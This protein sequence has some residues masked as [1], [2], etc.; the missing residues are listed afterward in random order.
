MSIGVR[1]VGPA[2]LVPVATIPHG[3][4]TFL[5]T[6][7]EGSTRL[8]ERYPEPMR[9]AL[10]VH[11]RILRTTIETHGGYV[12]S[13]AGDAFSAAYWTP[14]DAIETAVEAQRRLVEVPW[15]EPVILRVRMGIHTGTADERDGDY[16]G[17]ALNLA[18]RLMS[19]GHGGQIL[20]SLAT[21]ELVR[22]RS[23]EEL[24]FLGLGE[25]IFTGLGRAEK[26]FQ[27]SGPGLERDFP[28]LRTLRP[29][30]GNLARPLTSF[31]G[32]AAE[33]ERLVAELPQRRLITLTGPGGV[34]KTRLA[35]ESAWLVSGAYPD[36]T[37]LVE[38][39]RADRADAVAA[40][41]AEALG[42]TRQSGL[43]LMDSIA[44]TLSNR[45]ILVVI[46]NAEHV[47]DAT[48][49]LLRRIVR[50]CD[51][52]TVLVTSREPLTIDGERVWVV[53]PLDPVLE[54]VELFQDRVGA[55]D[56]ADAGDNRAI[57]EAL[58]RKLDGIPLAIE[59]AAARARS[60]TPADLLARL[61]DRFRLLR[62]VGRD[63]VERHQTMQAAVDWSYQLLRL[64]EQQ[65]F[66]RLAGFPESFDLA[67]A[68]QVCLDGRLDEFDIDDLLGSL[69][70]K[71]MVVAEAGAGGIRYRLLETLRQYG[72]D[73]LEDHGQMAAVQDRHI[74][75]YRVVASKARAD[76]EGTANAAGH[77]R[78][79]S[80]WDN[81]RA[82]LG[83]AIARQDAA[84]ATAIVEA[85]FWYAY[86][87]LN[88][89]H[90]D[91]AD[92]VLALPGAGI[93]VHGVA[94]MW[95]LIRGETS[96]G[97]HHGQL[98]LEKAPFPGHPGT[99][100]CWMAVANSHWYL[101]DQAEAGLAIEK[102]RLVAEAGDDAWIIGMASANAANLLVGFDNAAA[103]ASAERARRVRGPA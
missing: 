8:W 97:L 71:S 98:G 100:L 44:D 84:A 49:E 67:A 76:Y 41:V 99:A 22:D 56:A 53:P 72:R 33:L 1:P 80:E 91:W 93:S 63:R 10:A 45:R 35:L 68:E 58:C 24:G 77:A 60:M 92:H 36:G 34:G 70:D 89:E 28:P 3:T 74:A 26:V 65:V 66:D 90:G 85:S 6:D 87:G 103:A 75:H 48:A 5:F 7:V 32:R 69:V 86:W 50:G 18:A 61:G 16:F 79:E 81:L 55:V 37:W 95:A 43:S 13:T 96:D 64:E 15:P 59:L 39:A 46:D 52:L 82:A 88:H 73:R 21:E 2:T 11:D 27:L 42:A 25:H 12:F 47:L 57:V 4:V 51:G 9:T 83:W 17:P 23:P 14:R 30:P 29:R 20:V 102:C 38:L 54:G 94:G 78:L 19:A 101:G 62:M 31:V 40:V